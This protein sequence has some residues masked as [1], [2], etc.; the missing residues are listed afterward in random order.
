MN[1]QTNNQN[2]SSELKNKITQHIQELAEATDAARVSEE[3][4][5]YLDMCARFHKYS[6][7]NVWLILM[8]CPQATMVAGFKKWRTMG[9]YV[10]KGEKGIPILAP[11]LVKQA[12]EDE[13]V[14]E[15]LVGFKVVY[16]FDVNQTEG[17]DLPEPPDW[18]SPEQNELLSERLIKFAE[19]KGIKVSVKELAGDIQGVSMGGSVF[20][21][22]QAGTKTL[23]HE[24]AHEL[25]HQDEN[26]PHNKTILELEAESVAYVVAKHFGMDGLASPNYVALNGADAE[27][28]IT[29]LERI[30][31]TASHIICAIHSDHEKVTRFT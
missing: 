22:P 19:S 15:K 3:M 1:T 14:S 9:R 20:V 17:E 10:C 16:V 24:I 30:R 18:K 12:D 11:I 28:I 8:A 2:P 4:L 26:R 27:M 23:I 13:E 29:H 7:Q 31:N 21:S 6:P 5:S 25:M